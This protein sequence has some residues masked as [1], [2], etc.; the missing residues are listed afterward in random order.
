MASC[1]CIDSPEVIRSV[2]ESEQM[3]LVM[4]G[5]R[6]LANPHYPYELAQRLGEEGPSKMTLPDSYA[7]WLA[8]Y[9]PAA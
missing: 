2:I 4:I 3:D 7:H 5:R 9:T 8:R 6:H 1:W